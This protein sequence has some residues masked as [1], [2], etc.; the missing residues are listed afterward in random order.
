M[1]SPYGLR[2][3]DSCQSCPLR[4]NGYFCN[5]SP[6]MLRELDSCSRS[7]SYPQRAVLTSEGQPARGVF[8]V[9]QGKIKLSSTSRDGKAVILKIARPGEVVGM[10]AVVSGASY[11]CTAET[12]SPC[13]VRFI[14]A[15]DFLHMIRTHSEA[16]IHAAQSLS[17][18]CCDAY[19]EIR[20]LALAPTCASKLASLLLSWC[21]PLKDRDR[22]TEVRIHSSFTHEEIG[23]MI[24]TSRETVTRVFSDFKKNGVLESR[25]SA[26]IIRNL[27]AL[28]EMAI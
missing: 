10:S 9:C 11:E 23:E 20:S 18:E 14:A 6:E 28:Q 16:A 13:Q 15:Q 25:G 26:M 24:G 8:L 12:L 27:P 3:V 21:P 5:F 22:K 7:T 1:N 19:S 2:I 4:K 17:K